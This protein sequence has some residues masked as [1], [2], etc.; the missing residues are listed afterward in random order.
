MSHYKERQLTHAVRDTLSQTHAHTH[1]LESSF[2]SH[3]FPDPQLTAWPINAFLKSSLLQLLLVN[4]ILHELKFEQRTNTES[5]WPIW[6]LLL[7]NGLHNSSKSL[8]HSQVTT[9][10]SKFIGYLKSSCKFSN[11]QKF[12]LCFQWLKWDVTQLCI[13]MYTLFFT[14]SCYICFNEFTVL[15]IS[16]SFFARS[17]TNLEICTLFEQ[18]QQQF[19][20]ET[21]RMRLLWSPLGY[22]FFCIQQ[23]DCVIL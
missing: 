22:V 9:N 21:L 3:S 12:I 8:N 19:K 14:S 18:R 7:M 1:I 13:H 10:H 5:D 4:L 2:Y 20:L 11:S 23:R 6:K 16:V 15:K 17:L